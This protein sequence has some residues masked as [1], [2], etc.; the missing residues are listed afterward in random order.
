MAAKNTKKPAGGTKKKTSRPAMPPAKEVSF[1]G[2]PLFMHGA[3]WA[4]SFVFMTIFIYFDNDALLARAIRISMGGLF[5]FMAYTIPIIF[6]GTLI[7]MAV[8]KSVSKMW[9]KF[10]LSVAAMTSMSAIIGLFS[11]FSPIDAYY[12]SGEQLT[13]GGLL[14]VAIGGGL[15]TLAT[16]VGA[17]IILAVLFITLLCLLFKVNGFKYIVAWSRSLFGFSAEVGGRVKEKTIEQKRI[18]DEQKETR[19]LERIREEENHRAE[20]RKSTDHN[21]NADADV[22]GRLILN[23]DDD[24][25]IPESLAQRQQKARQR[26]EKEKEYEKSEPKPEPFNRSAKQRDESESGYFDGNGEYVSDISAMLRFNPKGRRPEGVH[27]FEEDEFDKR[28]VFDLYKMKHN[29]EFL[30]DIAE[31]ESTEPAQTVTEPE[32]SRKENQGDAGEDK[33]I[34]HDLHEGKIL[35][36]DDGISPELAEEI[37]SDMKIS[38]M[39]ESARA[40]KLTEDE[41][42]LYNDELDKAAVEKQ[43]EYRKPDISLLESVSHTSSS[44]KQE[45]IQKAQL[46]ISILESFGIKA[47]PTEVT[48]G[49]T[50]TRYEILPSSGTKLSKIVNLAD[51]IAL[52]LAVP[53]VLIAPVPGKAGTVGVEIPNNKVTPVKI[54]EML[55]S[56]EFINAKSKL[57]VCLGKDIGGNVVVGDIAKWPHALIAGATGSGKS[58][59]INTIIMSLLYKADPNEVKIMMIDPKQVELGIY[60]GIPHLLVPVVTEAKKAAGALNWAVKEMMYRY[61]L[62]KN[63]NTRKLEGYNAQMER[64]GG[65]KLPQ[66]V[67]IID[68]LADLMMVA[69][70]EVEDSICR[71]AQLARAAG[72]HLI[73]ATQRPSVDV[74]TGLI[75]ANIPS[76]I[77]FFVSSQVDSRTII[78]KAGAEKLL[79]MGDMLY[80]PGGARDT[81][82]IQGAFVSDDEVER[83]VEFIKSTSYESDYR[84]D[85]ESEIENSA[86]METTSS[87]EKDDSCDE[88]LESAV[89]LALELGKIS[90]SMVQRRL[91]VGYS[92]AGRLV[93]Q[94][95]ERG[96][97]TP[98]NG[99]K[100]RDVV[101][102]R[103]EDFL[104]M[105]VVD[106]MTEGMDDGEE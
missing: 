35:G 26:A 72:I 92:R 52:N 104:G 29:G 81:R 18:R 41:K 75:K 80:F 102:S 76:R 38:E 82:R 98:A 79:G 11:K 47:V 24:D 44:Q 7:Y 77:A 10:S 33:N 14:G 1:F 8:T 58:V 78:D 32:D 106:V 39:K 30:E 42:R 84:A 87:G 97:V 23:I 49:P 20:M 17:F 99:A 94:M 90:T 88:L 68:E 22:S 89:K 62:F 66:I 83:V 21:S 61:S 54:R 9:M 59:C 91:S 53:N 50:V 101:L 6:L 4:A 25:D 12:I 63:T 2:S 96:I 57:T 48:Q 103:A 27:Q 51:D 15:K 70:K 73:V 85:I 40:K 46:L 71:L 93:D 100:P 64:T 28:R 65:E 34:G 16:T 37:M 95:E 45:L 60:N 5:G 69:A 13:G 86:A 56:P 55:E 67:I 43:I 19:R 74:I 36:D 105:R 3:I 31:D